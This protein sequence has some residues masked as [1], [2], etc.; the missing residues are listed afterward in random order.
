MFGADHFSDPL[1]AYHHSAEPQLYPVMTEARRAATGGLTRGWNGDGGYLFESLVTW[2]EEPR[3]REAAVAEEYAYRLAN[4]TAERRKASSVAV[5]PPIEEDERLVRPD[6]EHR[7]TCVDTLFFV[8]SGRPRGPD[9]ELE[10]GVRGWAEGAEP[11][12]DAGEDVSWAETGRHLRFRAPI[13]SAVSATLRTLLDLGP[14]AAIPPFIGLHIRRGDF[15]TT[16]GLGLASVETYVEALGQVRERLDA[17]PRFQPPRPSPIHPS[18]PARPGWTAFDRT[19]MRA[20]DLPVVVATDETDPRFLAELDDRGWIVV[21]HAQ[22]QTVQR[23]DDPWMP[24]VL[25]QGVLS[26][27]AGL[28]MTAHSVR[29]RAA[30]ELLTV[31]DLLGPGRS[32]RPMVERRPGGLR[33]A[34]GLVIE[35]LACCVPAR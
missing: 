21:D 18:V 24:S 17:S 16:P 14:G 4:V 22:L 20:R 12:I 10:Y 19:R 32:T 1:V 34:G 6:P 5:L 9:I 23:Y 25:D 27:A 30:M 3:I 2:L 28:V 29:G 15:A 13:E 11:L 33:R 31:T 35:R 26:R 8:Q 7:F